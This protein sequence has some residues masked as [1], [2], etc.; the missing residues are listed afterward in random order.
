MNG[1]L[2]PDLGLSPT[3]WLFL[4]GLAVT[5]LFFKFNRVWSV[6]NL[7]LALVFALA[8]GLM[9]LIPEPA[10]TPWVPYAW[11]FGGS[12]LLLLRCLLDLGIPR[13]PLLEPN[14]NPPGL[15]LVIVGMLLLLLMETIHLPLDQGAQRNPAETNDRRLEAAAPTP[16]PT[17]PLPNLPAPLTTKSPP[18]EVL[19]RVLAGLAHLALVSGLITVGIVQFRRR[20]AGLAMAA[21]YLLLP[22]TRIAVVD[23]GQLLAAALILWAV[24]WR[25]HP[26]RTGLLLGLSAGWIPAGIGLIP[27][28]ART[29]PG[30]A[31]WRFLGGAAGVLTA[32]VALGQA[33]PDLAAWARALGARS[34]A[35]AGL[36]PLVR[37]AQP[38]ATNDPFGPESD[39][40]DDPT[41]VGFWAAVD[42]SYRLPVLIAYLMLMVLCTLFP[43]DKDLPALIAQSAALLIA[44][45]FWYLDRGGT[46]V[47]LYL[48][49]VLLMIF[50]PTVRRTTP[51]T[52]R[53]RD[54]SIGAAA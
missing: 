18:Q 23:S 49:M 44:S 34:L 3:T 17:P 10:G 54:D 33:I 19:S 35:S 11:L 5:A 40:A 12:A 28:W 42:P 15:G 29:F 48:P 6:R 52:I 32:C 8:P 2:V 37:E 26:L 30:S 45:Q 1:A 36:L 46:Q 38:L 25:N 53:S 14:L 27:L 7:D 50:R 47:L 4:T 41:A 21:C 16:L 31:R 43:G 24:V 20:V 22:Y 39:D 13:R 9:S 51:A